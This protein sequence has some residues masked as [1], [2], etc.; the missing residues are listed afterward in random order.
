MPRAWRITKAKFAA[1]A[2]NGEGARLYGGRWSSPGTSVV[3]VAESLSLAIL[4]ILVH[5]QE[6]A[7]LQDYVVSTIDFPERCI[8]MTTDLP[9]NWRDSPPPNDTQFI[10]DAWVRERRSLALRIPS[11]IT[12]TEFNYLINPAHRDFRRV[13]ISR[14][15]PLDVDPRVFKR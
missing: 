10:G 8:E 14:P 6:A 13:R 5:I 7:V 1:V 15:E 12:A 11:A 4:E 9:E 3:Y 2:F